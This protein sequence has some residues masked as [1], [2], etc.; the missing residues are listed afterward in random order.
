MIDTVLVANRGEIAVRIIRACR[1]LGVRSVAVY[2][3]ADRLAPHVQEA[4]A[5]CPV[6]PAASSE[7]YLRIDRILEAAEGSGA[8]AIHPGYGFLAERAAFA[9]A[10]EAA[11]LVFVGPTSST[12][13]AMGDKTEARRRMRDAGVP[14][15]PGLVDA[16]EDAEAAAEAAGTIGYPVLLKAAAGGGG[17][18]MRIVEREDDLARA[19][20]AA[21]REATAA[22]GDGSVYLERYLERPRH[23]EIQVMG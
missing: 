18:G 1:E 6:G 13:A 7:S 9:Q 5:A 23:V 17:K 10:V 20:E 12:I 3:E 15:V 22:F 4:D 16:V 19:F 14:I 8:D 21:S 2:S 11:G